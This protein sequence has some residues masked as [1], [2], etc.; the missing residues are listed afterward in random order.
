MVTSA[1][2]NFKRDHVTLLMGASLALLQMSRIVIA[3][4]VMELRYDCSVCTF[5]SNSENMYLTILEF[6]LLCSYQS[7]NKRFETSMLT[8]LGYA[9]G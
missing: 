3:L 6:V 2:S 9:R 5:G 8:T 7:W 1:A 4:S